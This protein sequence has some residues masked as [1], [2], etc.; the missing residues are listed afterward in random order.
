[1]NKKIY[2]YFSEEL[3]LP[4]ALTGRMNE[5][6]NRKKFTRAVGFQ[7]LLQKLLFYD[8]AKG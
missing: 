5:I 8:F 1:L 7:H 4:E 3:K 2:T 6:E